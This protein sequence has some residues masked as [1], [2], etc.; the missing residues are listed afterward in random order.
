[1]P[2][3]SFSVLHAL[4]KSD[5][6][7]KVAHAAV[8]EDKEAVSCGAPRAS[9]ERACCSAVEMYVQRMR[10]EFNIASFERDVPISVKWRILAGVISTDWEKWQT[11]I[12]KQRSDYAVAK[13]SLLPAQ[14]AAT[15][16]DRA[17]Q[18]L[19]TEI[20]EDVRRT[21]QGV[22]LFKKPETAD[23]MSRILFV[24]AKLYPHVGYI[25]GMNEI[26][27][28]V[29]YVIWKD[30]QNSEAH[31]IFGRDFVEPDAFALFSKV[32]YAVQLLFT[33]EDIIL[34]R[35]QAVQLM[36]AEKDPELER[37]L[38]ELG[39]QPELYMIRWIRIFFTQL[40]SLD[41]T[42]TIWNYLLLFG[43]NSGIVEQICVTL[44]IMI[45]TSSK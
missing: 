6:D 11:E 38:T 36:L 24:Y 44:L 25:Q 34:T 32:M 18:Q 26:L 15:S 41:D 22:P 28:V 19:R 3:E 4:F 31:D 1:M 10:S 30:A 42:V 37:A 5:M 16:V 23:A 14:A 9:S 17:T 2:C 8:N 7:K 43:F 35:C 33:S 29:L 13:A 27:A 21:C 40:F 12:T 45:R 20:G 39:I